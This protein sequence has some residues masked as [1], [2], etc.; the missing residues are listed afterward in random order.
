MEPHSA[1]VIPTEDG[2]DVFCTSQWI[3]E[4]QATTAQVLGI[5]ANKLVNTDLLQPLIM[6]NILSAQS[7]GQGG[8]NY[9][10]QYCF[11]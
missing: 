4:T 9:K 7:E 6:I 5:P 2:Y 10:L 3:T 1:R 8:K 11:Q